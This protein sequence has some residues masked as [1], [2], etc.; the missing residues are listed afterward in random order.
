MQMIQVVTILSRTK[1]GSLWVGLKDFLSFQPFSTS[2]S[3]LLLLALQ[4]VHDEPTPCQIYAFQKLA[5]LVFRSVCDSWQMA[6]LL[7]K[8]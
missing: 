5:A 1:E 7:R 6:S 3:S 8:I 2:F 4:G